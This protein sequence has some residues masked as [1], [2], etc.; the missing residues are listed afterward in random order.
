MNHQNVYH[1]TKRAFLPPT[2]CCPCN[3]CDNRA[4]EWSSAIV[5]PHGLYQLMCVAFAWK[6]LFVCSF[7]AFCLC[8]L[9]IISQT[10]LEFSTPAIG[11]SGRA[12]FKHALPVGR[13]TVCTCNGFIVFSVT[14]LPPTLFSV[15]VCFYVL[16][17]TPHTLAQALYLVFVSI[18][19]HLSLM[20]WSLVCVL[21]LGCVCAH[22][23]LAVSC[24][25]FLLL[26][27]CTPMF[28]VVPSIN[29]GFFSSVLHDCLAS[30]MWLLSFSLFLSLFVLVRVPIYTYSEGVIR[31]IRTALANSRCWALSW[32]SVRA[33]NFC[34]HGML[35][36]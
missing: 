34:I 11:D 26:F 17:C 33:Q 23:T 5:C 24:F 2:R 21:C 30:S 8:V 9:C 35:A 19:V 25:S 7:F 28:W 1:R 36:S 29:V 27:L 3:A 12:H 10:W 4:H 13:G 6:V 18:T 20:S 16:T 31:K 22:R 15:P 32:F 14:C